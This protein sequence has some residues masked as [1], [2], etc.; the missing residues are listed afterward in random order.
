MRGNEH[1]YLRGKT[2][3]FTP[4]LPSTVSSALSLSKSEKR[5]ETTQTRPCNKHKQ[6]V[7]KASQ[8]L[9]TPQ[10][11]VDCFAFLRSS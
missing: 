9:E 1:Q 4:G 10:P 3:A 6:A 7:R 2:A 5:R 8:S 11:T